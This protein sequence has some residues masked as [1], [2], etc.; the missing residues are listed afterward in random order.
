[1]YLHVH[2]E[3]ANFVLNFLQI[4]E[5]NRTLVSTVCGH[6]FCNVCMQAS[7]LNSTQ[8]PNCRKRLGKNQ[9]HPIYF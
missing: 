3:N 9:F 6:I 1:M 8:C 2:V 4:L 7:R 5:S